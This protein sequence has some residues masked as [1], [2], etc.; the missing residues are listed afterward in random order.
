MTRKNRTDAVGYHLSRCTLRRKHR[1]GTWTTSRRVR[2]ARGRAHPPRRMREQARS[3]HA[4]RRL[5]RPLP[6]SRVAR[7]LLRAATHQAGGERR[8]QPDVPAS[9]SPATTTTP[10]STSG[11]SSTATPR[12]AHSRP[13]VRSTRRPSRPRPCAPT[14][15][16]RPAE[17][18]DFARVV[19]RADLCRKGHPP[20]LGRHRPGRASPWSLYLLIVLGRCC[21]TSS[22]CWPWSRWS[23]SRPGSG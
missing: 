9:P 23:P 12:T 8:D 21:S 14:S 3:Q 2:R 20:A 13:S 18:I 11:A 6:D 4:A 22:S 19:R 15:S 17:D 7:A 16:G 5:L 10:P 1:E